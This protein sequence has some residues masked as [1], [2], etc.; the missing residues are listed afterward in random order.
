MCECFTYIN[1]YHV[2]AWS[3][4]GQKRASG[5]LDQESRMAVSHH[6]TRY[7]IPSY[8]YKSPFSH[9]PHLSPLYPKTV[10][11]DK[12]SLPLS[13]GPFLPSPLLL[14]LLPLPLSPVFVPY[15]CLL[16]LWGSWVVL[17]RLRDSLHLP[18]FPMS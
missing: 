8:L 11:R 4:E 15:S 12:H 9:V 14:S 17:S 1:V 5:P 10:P 3:Q 6:V 13:L 16:S 2:C 7:F 18:L